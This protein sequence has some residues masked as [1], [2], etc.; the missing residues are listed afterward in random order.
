MVDIYLVI[1]DK[2]D[3]IIQKKLVITFKNSK[4]S[5]PMRLINKCIDLLKK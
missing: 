3:T 5:N 2:H 4:R 1:K